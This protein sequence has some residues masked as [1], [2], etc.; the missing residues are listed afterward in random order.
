MSFKTASKGFLLA[1]FAVAAVGANAVTFT[2]EQISVSSLTT[3]A[4][5]NAVGNAI[6][7]LFPNALVG[8]PVAPLRGGIVEIVYRAEADVNDPLI[9]ANQV[10]VN[11]A[12]VTK[13]RGTIDFTEQIFEL[14]NSLNEVGSFIGVSTATFN[15]TSPLNWSDTIVLDRNVRKFRAK[16]TFVLS[17]PDS[18]DVNVLDLAALGTVNQS[19]KL[20][21][22][23]GTMIAL[24]A[25]LGAL[26]ARRRRK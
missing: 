9:F 3:G 20:V 21:P 6:T 22:E 1:S 24:A 4:S 2:V 5:S 19:V 11:L 16:K 15:S 10:F 23:P 14:D 25:G 13:G 18:V 17:A 8:D 12:Q 7:F 26:A